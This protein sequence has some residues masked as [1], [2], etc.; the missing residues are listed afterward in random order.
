MACPQ[1]EFSTK[2]IELQ[3]SQFLV[4]SS[5]REHVEYRLLHWLVLC[6]FGSCMLPSAN[7]DLHLLENGPQSLIPLQFSIWPFLGV[8]DREVADSFKWLLQ[9]D[10]VMAQNQETAAGILFEYGSNSDKL[11]PNMCLV[12]CKPEAASGDAKDCPYNFLLHIDQVLPLIAGS[13]SRR[14]FLWSEWS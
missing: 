11:A 14:L 10:Y 12:A 8:C 6:S 5:R 2:N 9:M 4:A 7:H 13:S 3:T 1:I